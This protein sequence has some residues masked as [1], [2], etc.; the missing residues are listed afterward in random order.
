MALL[1]PRF[2]SNPE[3]SAASENQPP[4][5]R[6][7][8]GE[9]VAILQQA[10]LDLGFAMPISTRARGGLPDGIYG[11]ETEAAVIAFQ[12]RNQLPADGVAG[13]MTMQRLEASIHVLSEAQQLRFLT[14][15][16]AASHDGSLIG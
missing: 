4:L 2:S 15:F 9:G 5:K 14:E 1:N 16:M 11:A 7:A 8:D 10:L 3:L 6:G 12:R 13:R